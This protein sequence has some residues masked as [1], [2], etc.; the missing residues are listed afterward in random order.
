MNTSGKGS[1]SETIAYE[2]SSEGIKE[3][4]KD[5]EGKM[6]NEQSDLKITNLTPEQTASLVV[7]LLPLSG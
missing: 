1:G 3:E 4:G 5:K 6:E 2:E 7:S